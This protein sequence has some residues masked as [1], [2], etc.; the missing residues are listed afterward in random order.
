MSRCPN[1]VQQRAGPSSNI[2]NNQSEVSPAIEN[3]WPKK[4]AKNMNRS[5]S[6][7]RAA[8]N[9]SFGFL[10]PTGD[11]QQRKVLPFTCKRL[12]KNVQM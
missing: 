7:K 2:D 10:W 1:D 11:A 6:I 5:S 9:K 3:V 4:E 12:A 8:G